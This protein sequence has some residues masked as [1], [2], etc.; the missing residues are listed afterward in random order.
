MFISILFFV[1]VVI[2]RP[3]DSREAASTV[4]NERPTSAEADPTHLKI[5]PREVPAQDD[6]LDF[7]IHKE[8]TVKSWRLGYW[9][10]L[11]Q[12]FREGFVI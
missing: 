2:A 8:S 7:S 11:L 3:E 12:S 4:N 1:E 10:N 5:Q 9:L 6:S